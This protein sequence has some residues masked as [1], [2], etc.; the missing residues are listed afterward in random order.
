[1]KKLI[2][3]R[4]LPASGKTTWAKQYL[5]ANPTT[6]RINKDDLRSMLDNSAWSQ[7]NENFIVEARNLLVKRALEENYSVIVDDTNFAPSHERTLREIA[8]QFEF[9]EFEVKDFEATVDECIARDLKRPVSVGEK[10]IRDMYEKY[11][12]KA[13]EPYP[14]NPDLQS[15]VLCDMDGTIAKITNRSPYDWENVDRDEPN[16]PVIE[17]IKALDKVGFPIFIVS[18]RDGR[19][20]EK[21]ITWLEKHQVPVQ[22]ILMRQPTDT[23]K[24]AIIKEEMFNDEIRGKYNVLMVFDDRDQVVELWR[25]KI[26]LKC[27]QVDYGNF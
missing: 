18:G 6:K 11:I 25:K 5:Q 20:L 24:D 14:N 19:A 15:V 2:M 13:P 27:F 9:T 12:F 22:K 21:T 26:G 3:L 4:G 23:R 16:I 10:V 1:M 7:T 17:T 8:S